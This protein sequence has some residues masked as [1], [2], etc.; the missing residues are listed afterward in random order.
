MWQEL[1][2]AHEEKKDVNLNRVKTRLSSKYNLGNA[3]KEAV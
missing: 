3:V 1:M 2:T